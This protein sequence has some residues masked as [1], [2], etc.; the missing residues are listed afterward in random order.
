MRHQQ[1]AAVVLAAL[2]LR[3]AVMWIFEATPLYGDENAYFNTAVMLANGETSWLFDT[4]QAVPIHKP[5]GAF[6]LYGGV[7]WIFGE[8]VRAI[9][10]LNVAVSATTPILGFILGSRVGGERTGLAFAV[11]LGL[12]PNL[13]HYSTGM[14]SESLYIFSF[15]AF[16]VFLTSEERGTPTQSGASSW[17]KYAAAAGAMLAA[18]TYVRETGLFLCGV[19]VVWGAARAWRGLPAARGVAAAVGIYLLLCAPWS[20]R[21]NLEDGPTRLMSH[22]SPWNLY[23]GNTDNDP[24]WRQL[25]RQRGE[26]DRIAN[27][28]AWAA[29]RERMPMWPI[30]K[31]QNADAFFLA[32]TFTIR[33]LTAP[34]RS[35]QRIRGRWAWTESGPLR[36]GAAA[37][38]MAV[39]SVLASLGAAGLVLLCGTTTGRARLIGIAVIAT[40]ALHYFPAWLTFS[41]TRF[42]VPCT[43]A[44]LLGAAW[45]FTH[46]KRASSRAT[47]PILATAAMTATAM[48]WLQVHRVVAF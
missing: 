12:H 35:R 20:F 41:I 3:I 11:L 10:L 4:R 42:A 2:V 38:I 48:L 13:V 5:P 21:L 34:T 28:L 6:A 39:E 14:W 32:R 37:G 31:L 47:W 45:L 1:L 22:N 26:R 27:E 24:D 18:T 16:L 40:I 46:G 17:W 8:S 9:R 36:K 30:E 44:L 29:I 43:P 7:L 15:L 19:G 33:R 23:K 25:H